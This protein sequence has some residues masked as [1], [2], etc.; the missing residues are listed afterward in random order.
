MLGVSSRW[1]SRSPSSSWRSP[2]SCVRC[3]FAREKLLVHCGVTAI[4]IPCDPE[5]LD[6]LRKK[7][8]VDAVVIDARSLEPS[9]QP[10]PA[11]V[12][13]ASSG[14]ESPSGFAPMSVIVL[15]NRH[16]PAWVRPMCERTG[17]RFFA[18]REKSSDYPALI[19]VLRDMCG[20]ENACCR[21]MGTCAAARQ[22]DESRSR[23]E[24]EVR[25]LTPSRARR[26]VA[27]A[28]GTMFLLAAVVGSGIMGDRL[29]GGNVADRAV[30]ERRSDRRR[31][32]RVD[33]DV[34]AFVG[35]ALQSGGDAC[36]RVEG[37]AVVA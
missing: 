24:T 10:A 34:R 35:R 9:E 1:P 29:S 27:E 30:G 36:G 32:G 12:A 11:F 18:T 5:A 2:A 26:T 8:R 21:P 7:V 4:E 20:V 23:G 37:R 13:M 25:V 28:V 6:T 19:R 22:V 14:G 17:A 31:V 16:V 3:R 15:G 33:P